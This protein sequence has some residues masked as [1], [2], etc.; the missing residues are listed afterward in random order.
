MTVIRKNEVPVRD[1]PIMTRDE[2]E[3]EWKEAKER[4]AQA[5]ASKTE[6]DEVYLA[7]ATQLNTIERLLKKVEQQR[8]GTIRRAAKSPPGTE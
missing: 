3:N 6:A 2:L 8:A 5:L 7:A 1:F 4:F